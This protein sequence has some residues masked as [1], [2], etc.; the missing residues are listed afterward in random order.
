M[1]RVLRIGFSV[2]AAAVL[3]AA[4]GCAAL[5]GMTAYSVRDQLV[6]RLRSDGADA[7]A[8]LVDR[9]ADDGT[10]T[11]AQAAAIHEAI[12]SGVDKLAAELAAMNID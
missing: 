1:A 4:S 3:L 2:V 5:E 11:A 6:D 9:L 12:P 7:A 8:G 10:I